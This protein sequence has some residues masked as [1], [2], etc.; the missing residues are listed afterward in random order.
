M[1]RKP[2]ASA[3]SPR[4]FLGGWAALGSGKARR[5]A[6]RWTA[7][8]ASAAARA[9][10]V[11]LSTRADLVHGPG[12]FYHILTD[13]TI[14]ATWLKALHDCAPPETAKVA[15]DV[16]TYWRKKC[17]SQTGPWLR[18][19]KARPILKPAF[20]NMLDRAAREGS[21]GQFIV[22]ASDGPALGPVGALRLPSAADAER[23]PLADGRIM[24]ALRLWDW[25]QFEGV[26]F[27]VFER[28]L[29]RLQNEF[30]HVQG[31]PGPDLVERLV[32]RDVLPTALAQG[33]DHYLV[34]RERCDGDMPD[35]SFMSVGDT[36]TAGGVPAVSPLRDAL[37]DAKCITPT[38]AVSAL[39]EAV[40]GDVIDAIVD[41]LEAEGV[42]PDGDLSVGSAFSGVDVAAARLEARTR[43][44]GRGF[45][46]AFASEPV[47]C[48]RRTLLRAWRRHG[49]AESHLYQDA[50]S[51]GARRERA[52]D[53]FTLT[54]VCQPF[55]SR[56][57]KRHARAKARALADVHAA[58]DYVRNASPRIV[59]V[60][61][62][63]A[64]DLRGHMD[65]M[66][67]GVAGYV[68]RSAVIDPRMV[69]GFA[70]RKRC[71]WVGVRQE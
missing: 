69:G 25:S 42:W 51:S 3:A 31:R 64:P 60:E 18:L 20:N 38:Q 58:L 62:V 65:M 66:L 16:F 11:V 19:R 21:M 50:R 5:C 7:F 13:K 39:G 40:H 52:V 46:V 44:V 4:S 47:A 55:S 32:Y 71:Y 61:N 68:W 54:P 53:V 48:R 43:R 22:S 26:G 70:A 63:D 6:P 37:H 49:L 59:I 45:S 56:N 12:L 8:A 2:V 28:A 35:V 30:P 23:R 36:A 10:I 29:G 67:L 15:V 24:R 34:V 17:C 33:S 1:G 41:C 14:G 9:C 27:L 57:R